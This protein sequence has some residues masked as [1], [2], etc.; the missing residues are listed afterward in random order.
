MSVGQLTVFCKNNINDFY[1]VLHEAKGS[2][3]SKTDKDAFS[4]KLSYWGKSPKI[5]QK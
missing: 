1:E 3:G 2:K 4:K 5:P